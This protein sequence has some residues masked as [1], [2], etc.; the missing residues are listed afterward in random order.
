M[1]L[2]ESS[3]DFNKTETLSANT[4]AELPANNQTSDLTMSDAKIDLTH[5]SSNIN[6][7]PELDEAEFTLVTSRNKRNK[8]KKKD[9][10]RTVSLNK[11]KEFSLRGSS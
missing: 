6:T 5:S 4:Y 1:T 8:G 2:D 9:Q 10:D 3:Q 7:T 11:N